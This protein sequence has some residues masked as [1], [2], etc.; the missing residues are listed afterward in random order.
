MQAIRSGTTIV[1]APGTYELTRTLAFASDPARPRLENVAIRGASANAADV[2]LVGKGMR[3]KEFGA[4]PH[5]IHVGGVDG[6]LIANLTIGDVY[7]HAIQLAGEM[8]CRAPRIYNCRLIDAGEQLVKASI[9]E[10]GKGVEGGVV[11]YTL[12]EYTTTARGS[13]TNGVDV[14]GAAH[15]CGRDDGAGGGVDDVGG[16]LGARVDVLP[17]DEVAQDTRAGHD[18]GA[19]G[20]GRSGGTM[21]DASPQIREITRP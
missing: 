10:P 9:A 17:A 3:N 2:V 11:E 16:L 14:L 18:G 21:R 6:I 12:F 7:L 5:G 13:Y 20:V 19:P 8:G 4:V 15:R 1:V